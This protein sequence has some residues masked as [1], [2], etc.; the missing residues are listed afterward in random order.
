MENGEASS[1]AEAAQDEL[2]QTVA[3]SD[4]ALGNAALHRL[5]L[6][7]ALRVREARSD[8][9]A[10]SSDFSES[11]KWTCVL[12]MAL[13]AQI[14]LAAVHL[15]EARAQIAAMVIFT[16]SIVLVIGLIATHEGPFHPPLGIRPAPIAKLLDIVPD[17]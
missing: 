15:D 7:T 3:R 12:L 5:L 11:A 2:L 14:S 10:L 6:D 13:M 9:L 1:E 16:A 17:I 4:I 8:R